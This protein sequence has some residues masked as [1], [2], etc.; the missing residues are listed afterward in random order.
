MK[1][2][3]LVK[4]EFAMQ[5]DQDISSKH[6]DMFFK[7]RDILTS[8]PNIKEIKNPKQTSYYDEYSSV[9]FIRIKDDVLVFALANGAKLSEKFPQIKGSQKIVR[10]IYFKS[11]DE[12]DESLVRSIIEESF[13]LNIEKDAI[14][15]LKK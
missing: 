14:K 1:L 13:I 10:H 9:C 11:I 5:F 4:I 6:S 12:I 2:K 15:K 8:Y 7:L 3:K